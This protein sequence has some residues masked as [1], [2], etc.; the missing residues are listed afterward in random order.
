M[1][2]PGVAEAVRNFGPR[3]FQAYEAAQV[4]DGLRQLRVELK[5]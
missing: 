4:E 2:R 3:F 1:K 5:L